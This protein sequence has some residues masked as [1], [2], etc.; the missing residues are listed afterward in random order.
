[1]TKNILL[2]VGQCTDLN[3]N[4]SIELL[5]KNICDITS[6]RHCVRA[7]NLTWDMATPMAT[8]NVWAKYLDNFLKRYEC[9]PP[10]QKSV[11]NCM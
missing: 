1:M 4:H 6:L 9:V 7:F 8:Y 3:I 11:N 10:I 5:A 2:E